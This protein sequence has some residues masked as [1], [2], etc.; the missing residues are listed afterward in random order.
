MSILASSKKRYSSAM[1]LSAAWRTSAMA[2]AHR[3]RRSAGAS[4]LAAAAK[5]DIAALWPEEKRESRRRLAKKLKR[6]REGEAK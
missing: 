3:N 4:G 5:A 6:M 1:W 2:A